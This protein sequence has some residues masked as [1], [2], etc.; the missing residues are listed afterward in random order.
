MRGR[1]GGGCCSFPS[2][3]LLAHGVAARAQTQPGRLL[4]LVPIPPAACG[5]SWCSR[6]RTAGAP[7]PVR[8]RRGCCLCP[9]RPAPLLPAR[10][11]ASTT[12]S[13][14]LTSSMPASAWPGPPQLAP[15]TAGARCCP[16]T[17]RPPPLRADSTASART[18]ARSCFAGSDISQRRRRSLQGREEGD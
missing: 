5:P 12:R 9:S 11:S 15:V 18:P 1:R 6:P 13:S 7:L 3:L 17:C 2:P 16:C 14:E 8:D 10:T 4:L